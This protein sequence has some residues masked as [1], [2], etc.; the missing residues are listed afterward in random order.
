GWVLCT[1]GRAIEIAPRVISSSAA[2][3][4][5]SV[6]L[7]QPDGPTM[8][9]NSPSAMSALTPCMTWFAAGRRRWRSTTSRSEMAPIT[10]SF[11]RVDQSF[12]DPA[13]HEDHD[14]RR[15]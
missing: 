3:I 5:S 7:P 6:D 15:R 9:T 12:D 13:L 10:Y 14:Q 8:T 1:R 11:L 2:T 4:L